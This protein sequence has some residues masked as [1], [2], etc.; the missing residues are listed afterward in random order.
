MLLDQSLREEVSRSGDAGM[1]PAPGGSGKREGRCS[2]LTQKKERSS[3]SSARRDSGVWIW[4]RGEKASQVGETAR[5]GSRHTGHVGRMRGGRKEQE[6]PC[7]DR[8]S[9]TPA[10]SSRARKT[11][12]REEE[13]KRVDVV[14]GMSSQCVYEKEAQ[15]AFP[16]KDPTDLHGAG[17]V[18][19]P[20]ASQP[21]PGKAVR[22]AWR[23][24]CG[25]L[26]PAVQQMGRGAL[27]GGHE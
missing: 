11:R 23:S 9:W 6:E 5:A 25:Q 8:A 15:L 17:G 19:P 21:T 2:L 3:L 13:T 20:A 1:A 14:R 4:G 10:A 12:P 7:G 16:G 22:T 27:L 26:V 18:T 24:S